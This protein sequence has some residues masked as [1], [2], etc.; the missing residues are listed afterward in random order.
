MNDPGLDG[1]IKDSARDIEEP[2]NYEHEGEEEA[3]DDYLAP[4]RWWFTSTAFP[5]LA[6]T[7]GPI[8]SAFNLCALVQEWR[9]YLPPGEDEAHGIDFPDPKW[10]VTV[11][12]ISL[13]AAVAANAALLLNMAR[14]V[15][16]AVAQPITIVGWYLASFLLIALVAVASQRLRVPSPP[17]HALTQA[18]YY[19]IMAAA[20]YFIVA[21]LMLI[22]V[23]GAWRQYYKSEFKLTT[24]QRTLMLQTISFLTYLLLGAVV[25]SHLEG[26]TF[27]D[28]V[29][30]ADFTL[31]TVGTGD[32][33]PSTHIGRGLLFPFAI[34]GIVILGLVVGSIRSLILERGKHK[35][36]ARMVEKTREA[37]L[38]RSDPNKGKLKMTPF[39]KR[40]LAND[41][42]NEADRRRLEFEAMR[43]IQRQATRN[44]QWTSL[45]ISASAWFILWFVGAVVF[46]KSERPQ[47]WT[48][49]QALYYSY[50]SLLTIGYGDLYPRSNAGK[51]FF[52]FWSLL[53]I[54]TLTILISN[55]GDTVIKSI[56]DL[57]LWVGSFTVLPEDTGVLETVKINAK[58][59]SKNRSTENGPE[60]EEPPG[61]LDDTN[62]GESE[63]PAH[64]SAGPARR[65]A[66]ILEQEEIKESH[67]AAK[68]GNYALADKHHYHYLLVRE[69]RNVMQ[70]LHASPAKQYTYDEWAWFL[71][72]MGE[73]ESSPRSHRPPIIGRE[74]EEMGSAAFGPKKDENAPD[75]PN[76]WS[77]LGN[78][79]PLM[80]NSDE[81]QWVLEKLSS[82][83]ERALLNERKHNKAEQ[84]QAPNS[85][86]G[87]SSRTTQN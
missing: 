66:G 21:T 26:W 6:G 27:L 63:T 83:L 49:F 50:V 29:Y 71:K 30:F 76:Q 16:F 78:R 33:S 25:Y 48:Y 64:P 61:F 8:A 87:E 31:L 28:A 54:P 86:S 74:G 12:A 41:D 40:E 67:D 3:E 82:T 85:S 4:S 11:N 15:S 24:S 84:H 37:V 51:A 59:I 52:V 38:R 73:D 75:T 1:P 5:L 65:V 10:L 69:I 13:I 81:P 34:G 43:D 18:F 68:K 36:E 53:A 55:M 45:A 80:G 7:F 2:E 79:S 35:I 39:K 14:R 58:K 60:M 56:K 77:W 62:H 32:F 70:H 17:P 47:E 20:L 46:Y 19:A 57:T 72:L 42:T 9:D 22:T 23:W 44:R